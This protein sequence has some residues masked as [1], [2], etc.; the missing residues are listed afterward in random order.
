MTMRRRQAEFSNLFQKLQVQGE[1]CWVFVCARQ[2]LGGKTEINPK[3]IEN[4]R[5]K[6]NSELDLSFTNS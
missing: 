5:V 1:L 4:L 3:G 6:G 2:K